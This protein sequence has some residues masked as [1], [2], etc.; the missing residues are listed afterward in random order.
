MSYVS[1]RHFGRSLS[2]VIWSVEKKLASDV[3]FKGS[4]GATG[5]DQQEKKWIEIDLEKQRLER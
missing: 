4:T 1:E 3:A 5:R 2:G